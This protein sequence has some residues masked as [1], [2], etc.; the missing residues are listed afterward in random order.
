[1][2][3][4]PH[5]SKYRVFALGILLFLLGAVVGHGLTLY[6]FDRHLRRVFEHPEEISDQ[7]A[8]RIGED[9]HLSAADVEKIRAIFA[10]G[11]QK[12]RA[13]HEE[14]RPKIDAIFDQ[15]ETEVLKVLPDDEARKRLK[16]NLKRYFPRPPIDGPEDRH[17][18]PGGPGG[19]MGPGFGP[20][21][22][23]MDDDGGPPMGCG[24]EPFGRPDRP[25]F[26]PDDL[27][28]H[29]RP[30]APDR[31]RAFEDTDTAGTSASTGR[32]V[33]PAPTAPA[34]AAPEAA[35]PRP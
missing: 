31:D 33:A 9:F 29:H 30:P 34:P 25:P 1:M 20:D 17:G 16:G 23:P 6:M 3:V 32:L 2:T 27:H 28:G 4:L 13:L 5:H 18:G 24:P 15:F 14:T 11:H 8:R 26:P 10:E 35:S 22:G 21:H 7:I 12:M 19:P